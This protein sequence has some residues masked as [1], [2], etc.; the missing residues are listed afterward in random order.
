MMIL[1]VKFIESD[2]RRWHSAASRLEKQAAKEWDENPKRNA[3]GYSNLVI[4]NIMQ[5]KG[6]GKYASYSDRYAKWKER[7]GRETGFWKLFGDLTKSITH[8]R[9]I[10]NRMGVRAWMGG[11]PSNMVD[12]GGKSWFGKGDLG[13]PKRIAMYAHVMEYGGSWPKA[14]KHPPRPIFGPT[15]EEYQNVFWWKEFEYSRMRIKDKWR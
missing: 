2:L 9:V 14:G 15:A 11:I 8:F 13:F 6:M 7:Y 12:S 4:K 1:D 10:D 5:Q 3:I